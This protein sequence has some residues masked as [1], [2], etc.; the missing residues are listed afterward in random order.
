[1][2]SACTFFVGVNVDNWTCEVRIVVVAVC[3]CCLNCMKAG[4]EG[5]F[6]LLCFERHWL[7]GMMR[8]IEV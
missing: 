8:M 2:S 7:S 3:C 4:Q 5:V 1:M 6:A